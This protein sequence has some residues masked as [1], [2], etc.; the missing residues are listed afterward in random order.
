MWG[1][2]GGRPCQ[3]KT[4]WEAR[5]LPQEPTRLL[6]TCGSAARVCNPFNSSNMLLSSSGA[7]AIFT[8]ATLSAVASETLC[9]GVPRT[10]SQKRPRIW[11]ALGCRA[12]EHHRRKLQH[13]TLREEGERYQKNSAPEPA[14]PGVGIGNLHSYVSWYMQNALQGDQLSCMLKR[15]KQ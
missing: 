2:Q 6:V 7:G 14:T 1:A 15:N 11:A 4:T 10:A 13:A 9:G 5:S 8:K 12:W 3:H